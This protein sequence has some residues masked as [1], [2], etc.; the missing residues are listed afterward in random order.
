MKH[1]DRTVR[2]AR[3]AALFVIMVML[4]SRGFAQTPR[5]PPAT[6]PIYALVFFE[7][8]AG[9]HGRTAKVLRGYAAATR[10]AD[11]N[12][13]VLPLHEIGRPARFALV[14]VWRDKAAADAHAAALGSLRG[15][16]RPVLTAPFDIRAN[17]GLEVPG[18]KLGENSEA[19]HPVYVLTHVDVFPQGK[20]ET[21]GMLREL[22]AASR[23]EAGNLCFDLLQQDGH[24]NHLPVIEEWRDV[25]A[26]NAHTEGAPARAFRTKLVTLQGAL[27]DERLYQPIR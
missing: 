26:Q 5:T 24:A 4:S 23:K 20:D 12:A 14:E 17:A 18:G 3:I 19:G 22:A 1:G 16:L 21:I 9:S 25:A 7:T 11:G 15:A 8:E 13:A 6:G 27:Y 2:K 10:V